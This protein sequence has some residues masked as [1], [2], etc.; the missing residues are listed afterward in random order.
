MIEL[1]DHIS[2][3]HPVAQCLSIGFGIVAVYFIAIVV[4]VFIRS[5]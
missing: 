3:L 5:M 1:I 2:K 4:I